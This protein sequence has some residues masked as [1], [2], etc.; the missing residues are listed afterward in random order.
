MGKS[1]AIANLAIASA[2]FVVAFVF[3][4]GMLF[5][6]F[7]GV[8]NSVFLAAAA[9]IAGIVMLVVAKLPSIRAGH[10]FTFGPGGLP[11]RQRRVYLSAWGFITAAVL[12]WVSIIPFLSH[13]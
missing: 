13:R 8:I 11:P 7:T 1:S 5:V 6:G 4:L 3:A 12:L 9:S 10:W 2:P